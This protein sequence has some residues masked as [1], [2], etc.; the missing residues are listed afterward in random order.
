MRVIKF[1]ISK[2]EEYQKGNERKTMWHNVGTITEFHK[3][4][5]EI[6]RI[7]EIP[8]IGLKANI[9]PMEKKENRESHQS[10]QVPQSPQSNTD[11][12][13]NNLSAEDIPF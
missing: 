6:S 1:N 13:F 4:G 10:Q 12:I 9:F 2:P 3:D 11:E 7:M 8:A 5:G